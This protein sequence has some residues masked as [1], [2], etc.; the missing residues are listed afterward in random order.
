MYIFVVCHAHTATCCQYIVRTHKLMCN[1]SGL[2]FN[3]DHCNSNRSVDECV[4]LYMYNVTHTHT[5]THTHTCTHAHTG[6]HHIHI[7]CTYIH[8]GLTFTTAIRTTRLTSARIY[9]C[10][11]VHTHIY[12][13][14]RIR[15]RTRTRHIHI[16]CTYII[17][18][19]TFTTAIRTTRS[20]SV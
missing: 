20:T 14:T 10:M 12:T 1:E 11:N 3:F 4:H 5:H 6:T 18:V 2:Q 8:P 19:L 17:T 7:V 15:T 9:T 13:H 16:I